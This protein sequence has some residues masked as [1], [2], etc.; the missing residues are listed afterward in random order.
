MTEKELRNK[1]IKWFE[2]YDG[3]SKGSTKHEEILKIFNNSGLCSRYKMTLKDPHCATTVSAMFIATGLTKIFPCVECS[4][5]RMIEK[6]KAAGIWQEKDNYVPKVGDVIM[7]DWDD[8]G[9]GDDTG[10]PEHTGMVKSVGKDSMVINEGNM[11]NGSFGHRT[12][13]LNGRFIRGF[14]TPK[15]SSLAT[16]ESSKTIKTLETKGY[17]KGDK[18]RGVLA[19]K[20][21]LLIAKKLKIIK[22]GVDENSSFGN[23]TKNAA[24]EFLKSKGYNQN[25]IIGSKFIKLLCKEINKKI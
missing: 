24:N 14:I 20:E 4:C 17:K 10:A 22:G 1:P 13:K 11:A 19:V 7:Y 15:Y 9:S 18:T 25:G 6:A 16:K 23:G 8:N 21:L 12:I 5:S 2:K 3:A